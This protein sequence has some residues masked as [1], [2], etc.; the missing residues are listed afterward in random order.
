MFI[1]EA[2]SVCSNGSR[3]KTE[4]HKLFAHE[5]LQATVVFVEVFYKSE[6]KKR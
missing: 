5:I 4:I 1:S 3:I 2:N 6:G